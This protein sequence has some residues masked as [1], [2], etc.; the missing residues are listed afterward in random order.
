[1]GIRLE[2]VAELSDILGLDVQVTLKKRNQE[3]GE[4]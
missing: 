2:D 3:A 1:M 4:S